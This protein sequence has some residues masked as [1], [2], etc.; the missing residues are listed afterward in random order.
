MEV[1]ELIEQISEKKIVGKVIK[2]KVKKNLL[3]Y[4]IR[5]PKIADTTYNGLKLSYSAKREQDEEHY[6]FD[7]IKVKEK[8][9]Q[10]IFESVIDLESLKLKPLIWFFFAI[11][12]I[13]GKEYEMELVNRD[14]TNYAKYCSLFFQNSYEYEDG[15]FVYPFVNS[16]RNIALQYRKRGDYDDIRIKL[17]ERLAVAR[18]LLT[19]P[20]LK[21]KNI[22]LVFEKYSE[23]A[24]DNGYYFFRYCMEHNMEKAMECKI[25]YVITKD[26]PDREKLAPYMN[27]VIDFMSIRYITYALAAKLLVST[28]AK[29]HSYAW[30]RKGSV[31]FPFIK[32][33]KLVFLQH[34]VTA[35]KQVDF[36][37]GK[38]KRGECDLFITTSDFEKKIVE[39]N[40]GYQP[41]QIP[42]TGFARWDVLEDQSEGSRDILVMPTWRSWLEEYTEAAFRES[43]YYKQYMT[44]LKNPK[45]H[46]MLEK[47]DV[48]VKFYLHPKFKDY[49]GEFA[50]DSDRIEFIAFG[51]KPLNEIMMKCRMLVTDYSSVS[52]DMFYQKKPVVF[53]Q[54]DLNDYLAVH[55]SYI[56]MK[57]DL[58]GPTADTVEEL[59]CHMEDCI[60]NEFSLTNEQEALHM[61][62]FKYV[63]D[64]NSERICKAIEEQLMKGRK[65][66][67]ED[68]H[69]Q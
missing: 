26:S 8:K 61:E 21:H 54:F 24:Q 29:A 3:Y 57:K 55:G 11:L 7:L 9:E 30:R 66:E 18:Y 52:W 49:I 51:T 33:K 39:D 47:H 4:R 40:F 63:D 50:S 12:Q 17:K 42:V 35:M 68:E 46:Q 60:K 34:G 43:D 25:Y 41:D 58:F 53:Y 19:F 59:I 56:D 37:Y 22:F 16:A 69:A 28:D 44:L 5:V 14:Y 48:T 23:M 45:F 65:K 27:N 6:V 64:R 20:V 31:L 38:G 13:D 62:Y 67:T 36:F 1:N 2:A 15:M 10:I 32:R